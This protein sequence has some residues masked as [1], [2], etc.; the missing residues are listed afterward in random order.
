MLFGSC[1]KQA[2]QHRTIDYSKA[3]PVLPEKPQDQ[4]GTAVVKIEPGP[5]LA[6]D[7][8]AYDLNTRLAFLVIKQGYYNQKVRDKVG[9]FYKQTN[10]QTRWLHQD[11]PNDLYYSF[12]SMVK[13]SSRYGMNP[14]EYALQQLEERVAAL[15]KTNPI[16]MTEAY[17]LDIQLTGIFFLF[18]THVIDGRILE[19]GFGRDIW[20]RESAR[21]DK[22]DVSLL[23]KSCAAGSCEE[24]LQSLHPT[25]EQY[26]KL[27]T[28]LAQYRELE[29]KSPAISTIASTEPIKPGMNSAALP[30]IRKRLVYTDLALSQ[31]THDSTANVVTDS[32]YYDDVL[33]S[34]VKW[35]QYRHGLEPDGVIG[36]GTLKFMNQSFREKADLIALNLERLRW[37]RQ[38]TA[39]KLII[40]N[41]PEYK[42]RLYD[43]NKET[44]TM[45]VIV[46]AQATSTPVFSDTLRYLVFSPTW[47]VPISI[48]KGEIIPHLLKDSAYYNNRNYRFY[49]GGA[50]IDPSLEN[51]SAANP[52]QYTVV[53]L[54]GGDN[55]LGRVKFVMPNNMSIYMHDTPNHRLFTKSYRAMSHGCVRLDEPA[56][57]AEYLLHD[58]YGW[59]TERVKKAMMGEQ[60]MTIILKKPYRIQL[61]YRT[62]WVDEAGLVNFREDIYGHDRRQIEWLQTSNK[63]GVVI[64]GAVA[65]EMP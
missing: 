7:T 10:F 21:K 36:K 23:A 25:H 17:N 9:D 40:V 45:R 55:A 16:S 35:F 51:W 27:Q 53:Q 32:T 43:N 54:P 46:G 64:N 24:N 60:P 8:S 37:Q 50:E 39:E 59:T 41:L 38:Q 29:K 19:A 30:A 61:E 65:M 2:T 4:P 12:T 31:A 33:V 42:M 58:Q 48:I 52:N 1:A 22:L 18:T 6:I 15:Y 49:K 26:L 20:I 14:E 11:A 56:R 28:A 5:A 13:S 57:L 63:Q 44:M 62:T 3:G 34:A 47:N